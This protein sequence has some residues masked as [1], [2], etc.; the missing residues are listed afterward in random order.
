MTHMVY[1]VKLGKEAEGLT[2]APYPG[3]LGQRI[4][5]NV[6]A[7]AWKLWLRQQ[8]MFINEYRLSAID[9]R[10]RKFLEGEME[11]FFFGAGSSP[12]VDFVPP[13]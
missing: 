5:Q 3:E 1:C 11:K 10:A 9:P 4:Y 2:F 8:T 12:P 6:S 13:Q 7:D